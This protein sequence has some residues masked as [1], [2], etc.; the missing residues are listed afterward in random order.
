MGCKLCY[1][2]T[3]WVIILPLIFKNVFHSYQSIQTLSFFIK[4]YKFSNILGKGIFLISRNIKSAKSLV[5]SKACNLHYLYSI[6]QVN[7]TD[8]PQT[9]IPEL[10][11]P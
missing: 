2:C 8:F 4:L 6:I 5:F 10:P 9:E 3:S 7:P 11:S 1:P